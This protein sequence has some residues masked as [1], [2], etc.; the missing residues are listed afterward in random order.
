MIKSYSVSVA[1]IGVAALATVSCQDVPKGHE[2]AA[3]PKANIAWDWTGIIGTGQSLEV[4]QYGSPAASTNQPYN[5]LKLTT[6][7][8]TWP[9]DPENPEIK[10]APLIEPIGRRGFG[11]W[12][13]N[14]A[15]ETPHSAMANELSAQVRKQ[16]GRDLVSVHTEV[17]ENGHSI[18]FIKKNPTHQ[19][20]WGHAYEGSMVETKAITRLAK[21]AGK[22]YG[23]GAIILTHGESDNGNLQYESALHQLW[24]DY[25]TDIAAITGQTNKILMILSQQH[26]IGNHSASTLEEWR[27]GVDYPD[28]IV[29]SGPKYQYQSGD[30]LHLTTEGYRELGEKYAQVYYQRV[31]LGNHWLPLEVEQ[32]TRDGRTITVQFHVPVAPLMWDT[33]LEAPHATVAEWKNGKG[34]EVMSSGG[35]K[36]AIDS[37]EIKG[38]S[39]VI[40]CSADPGTNA[41][42]SYALYVDGRTHMTKPFRG[43]PRWG[44]LHDSDPFTGTVTGKVQPNYAVSFE[45]TVP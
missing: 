24:Q 19:G 42:V 9:I 1:V 37:A 34:F 6:G 7:T 32:A 2:S 23:V 25:N 12:P 20:N 38:D 22:S 17:G 5:N 8:L 45:F 27:I 33:N 16:F 28:D 39:V 40:T 41:K 10:L 21:A 15:G 44:L 29:C 14:I 31:I 36:V 35:Q 4:G 30:S 13:S 26:G 18:Q 3:K 11:G 43:F